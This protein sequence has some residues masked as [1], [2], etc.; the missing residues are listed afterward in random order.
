MG[1][2]L[3]APLEPLT[4]CRLAKSIVKSV[5]SLDLAVLIELSAQL[6]N[7]RVKPREAK[8]VYDQ[9]CGRIYYFERGLVRQLRIMAFR[10]MLWWPRLTYSL[11]IGGIRFIR[12]RKGKS[13][14]IDGLWAPDRLTGV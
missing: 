13:E 9:I 12:R 10:T 11:C 8:F 3:D 6:N 5:P 4:R 1:V 14:D 7:K 2:L